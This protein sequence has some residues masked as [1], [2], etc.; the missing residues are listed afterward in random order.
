MWAGVAS[1]QVITKIIN[2]NKNDDNQ[3]ILIKINTYE[4]K[5]SLICEN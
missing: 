4:F 1:S 5:S 3:N 2:N